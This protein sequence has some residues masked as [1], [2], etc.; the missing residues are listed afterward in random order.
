MVTEFYDFKADEWNVAGGKNRFNP[1]EQIE[2]EQSL[3]GDR[4]R[5]GVRLV[6]CFFASEANP[7]RGVRV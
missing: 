2:K 4:V 7:V 6:F 1:E 3:P 5:R